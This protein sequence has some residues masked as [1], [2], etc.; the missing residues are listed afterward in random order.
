MSGDE[1]VGDLGTTRSDY[2]ADLDWAGCRNCGHPVNI[3]V[4]V[5]RFA[6][7]LLFHLGRAAEAQ[8]AVSLEKAISGISADCW[9]AI[10][11]HH[12]DDLLLEPLLEL[13]EPANQ[14][15]APKPVKRKRKK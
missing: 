15:T 5:R 12:Y 1:D 6:L 8:G 7:D 4:P 11:W 2:L 14:P 9:G 13:R 3:T 10:E